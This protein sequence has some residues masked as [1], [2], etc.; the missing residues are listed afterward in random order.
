MSSAQGSTAGSQARV[1]R[2]ILA[3]DHRVVRQ[4]LRILLD[5]R[6]EVTIVGEC[7]DGRQAVALAEK[8]RPDIVVMDIAMPELNGIEATRQIKRVSPSTR[9]IMLSAFGDPEQVRLS[10][11]AGASGYLIK[12]S[13]IEELVMAITLVSRGNTYFSSDLAEQI[14]LSELIY[15]AKR[16]DQR[17]ALDRLTARELEVLQLLAEGHTGRSIA[18]RLVI[19]PKTVEGHKARLM[20][21]VGAKNRTDLLRFALKAELVQLEQTESFAHTGA[22]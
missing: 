15:E 3:D 7:D 4:S 9:V 22:G 8:L 13:D 17:S 10:L 2:T 19:S 16:P 6:P 18:E 12:R 21:K 20:A 11:R 14:D 5:S 1:V